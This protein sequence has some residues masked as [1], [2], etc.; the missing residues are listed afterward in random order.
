MCFYIQTFV[1]FLCPV[2]DTK[3]D[4]FVKEVHALKNLHHPKLIQLLALCTRG[5][6]VYI[7][8]ELM[9]KGSLKSYLSCKCHLPSLLCSVMVCTLHLHDNVW[10]MCYLILHKIMALAFHAFF[11]LIRQS[12]LHSNIYD[13][14]WLQGFT[15]QKYMKSLNTKVVYIPDTKL[16]SF[17]LSTN[18]LK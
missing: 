10:I 3:V 15:V 6:P 12:R 2:E 13:M 5:E 16:I 14:I 1:L 11:S 4:E 8:T 9:T 7:V 18:F 17:I